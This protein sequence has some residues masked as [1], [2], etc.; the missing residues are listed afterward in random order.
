MSLIYVF[1][2]RERDLEYAI[3]DE[4]GIDDGIV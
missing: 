2:Y 3:E 1:A 4:W